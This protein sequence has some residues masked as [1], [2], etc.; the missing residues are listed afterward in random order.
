MSTIRGEIESAVERLFADASLPWQT[1]EDSG[2][3]N[4]LV[5]ESLGGFG[6]GWS[7]AFIVLCQAA[8][9]AV[10]SPL[11]TTLVARR[12]MADAGIPIPEGPVQFA[13]RDAHD[14]APRGVAHLL[15]A[16]TRDGT[17]RLVLV[18]ERGDHHEMIADMHYPG[19]RESFMQAGALMRAAQMAGALQA[20]LDLATTHANE[21]SQFGKPLGRFQAIQQQLAVLA[22]EV[23]AVRCAAM[24]AC[25]AADLGDASFEAAAAKLRANLAVGVATSIA[26]E[27]H[28]AIGITAEHALHRHTGHLW[29][30][31]SGFGNDRHWAGILGRRVLARG[32]RQLWPDLTARGDRFQ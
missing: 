18:A 11:D 19:A 30:W 17:E 7:E 22:E 1:L 16:I 5:P 31:R 3:P 2:V 28:G 23:A 26:H 24:A 21:R 10:A 15:A 25:R 32:A 6:G 4:V 27:V 29:A 9:R 20:C 12:L 14:L 13:H 8:L